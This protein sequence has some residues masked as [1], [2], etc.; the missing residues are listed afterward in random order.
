MVGGLL[1]HFIVAYNIV[2]VFD[3]VKTLFLFYRAL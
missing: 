3:G 2:I 1:L